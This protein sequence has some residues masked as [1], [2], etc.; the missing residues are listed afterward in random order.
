MTSGAMGKNFSMTMVVFAVQ[1]S[2]VGYCRQTSLMDGQLSWA[3][4]DRMYMTFQSETLVTLGV[5]VS[6]TKADIP[7][8][9][10]SSR[11]AYF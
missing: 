8:D 5:G 1:D 11:F 3:V 4:D 9:P 10:L 2:V 6:A 7:D